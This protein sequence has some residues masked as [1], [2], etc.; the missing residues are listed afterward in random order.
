MP[1]DSANLDI[2]GLGCVAVDDLLFVPTYPLADAKLQVRRRERQCGGLTG[3]EWA[4]PCPLTSSP[5]RCGI[6]VCLAMR[7]IEID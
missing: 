7:A 6:P 3:T 5:I 2:I 1:Q 4:K